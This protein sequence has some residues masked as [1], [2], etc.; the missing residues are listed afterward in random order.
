MYTRDHN[1]RKLKT[2]DEVMCIVEGEE[3]EGIVLEILPDNNV[4]VDAEE[5]IMTL[6]GDDVYYLPS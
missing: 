5:R 2:N 1:G 3:Y 4:K 6:N